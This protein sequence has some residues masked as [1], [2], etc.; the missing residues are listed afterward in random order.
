MALTLAVV[1]GADDGPDDLTG[2]VTDGLEALRQRI[3]QRLRFERGTWIF[4]PAAGFPPIIGHET[5]IPLA[6]R[7]ITEAIRDEGGDEIT[8]IEDVTVSLDRDTRVFRYAARVVT[9]Y[10]PTSLAETVPAV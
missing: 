3:T 7:A 8:S 2:A 4:A 10:G 9:I 1:P 5:T 6:Q